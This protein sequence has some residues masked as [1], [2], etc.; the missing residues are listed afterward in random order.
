MTY[1]IV[2]I[3]KIL[4]GIGEGGVTVRYENERN[5]L[6]KFDLPKSDGVTGFNGTKGLEAENHPPRYTKIYSIHRYR[7]FFPVAIYFTLITSIPRLNFVFPPLS[8]LSS[9]LISSL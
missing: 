8:V 2:G 3:R 1:R 9:H 5:G 6:T 7:P 4:G